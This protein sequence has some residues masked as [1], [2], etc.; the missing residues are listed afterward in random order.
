M[1]ASDHSD[2]A[3]GIALLA[4]LRDWN[5]ELYGRFVKRQATAW[6]VFEQLRKVSAKAM[7]YDPNWRHEP[8][9]WMFAM[10]G[11]NDAEPFSTTYRNWLTAQGKPTANIDRIEQQG[12]G[13]WPRFLEEMARFVEFGASFIAR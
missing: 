5:A 6:E 7:E 13:N 8:F 11:K 1:V 12:P 9:I 2:A 3:E 10:L 4:F